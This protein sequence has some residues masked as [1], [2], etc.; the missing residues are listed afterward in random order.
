MTRRLDHS[1]ISLPSATLRR[2]GWR[3]LARHRWQTVLMIVGI[4][5]GVAVAVA[6]DLANAGASRAFD[7]STEAVT[8]KA[9]HEITG[10]SAG[11]SDNTYGELRRAGVSPAA[12]VVSEYAVSPQMGNLPMQLLGIDPFAEQPFRNYL[13]A[14]GSLQLSNLVDFFTLPGSVIISTETARRYGL[15]AGSPL[16]LTILGKEQSA[17]IVGLLQPASDLSRRMLDD[18][19]ICDVATAQELTGR[20]G[21]L[22]RI[23]LIVPPGESG[24]LQ[25]I[26]ALLPPT[27]H[28]SSVRAR[29]GAIEQ[30]TAAF[31]LDL[32]AM[33][34][35]ALLV[36]MFLIYNTIT[37]SV[38]QRRP[39]F[40]TL[41]CLGV[42]R[43]EVFL[44]V[45]GEALLVGITGSA[46]GIA[47][48][49][50]LGQGALRLVTQ[51]I[52]DL[53]F[54]VNVRDA[55]IA[56][57]SLVK[58]AVLGIA[59]TVVS[60][61]P[62]AWEAASAP[63]RQVLA[64]SSLEEKAQ[65]LVRWAA[66]AGL[67][68]ALAGAIL[69]VAPSNS[70][71]VAFAGTFA[72]VIGFAMLTPLAMSKL[73]R[74]AAHL[75]GRLWGSLG[76]MAPRNVVGSLSRTA[77]AMA[78]L[79]VAVSVAI[80]VSVMIS[81]FRFS[82]AGWLEQALQ[83]DIYISAPGLTVSRGDTPLDPRIAPL[84]ESNPDVARLDV[85]RATVVD[86]AWGPVNV[87]A[88]QNPDI[89]RVRT[90]I[91]S[92][93]APAAVWDAL[94]KGAVIVSEPFARRIGLPT[95]GGQVVLI[96]AGGARAF[97]VAGIYQD[98]STSEGIVTM[99]LAEYRRLWDDPSLSSLS[100][101]LRPDADAEATLRGLQQALA[102]L[103][104]LAIRPS[105]ELR[106]DVL[107][108][109]DRTFTITGALQ[110]LTTLV[111]FVGV[112]S[113]LLS[114]QLDRQRDFGILRAIGL[115]SGQMWGLVLLETGLMGA[116]AGLLALPTGCVV[117]WILVRVINLR[118]FGWTLQLRLEPA[119]FLAAVAVAV[120]ASIL[121]GVYPAQRM[122]R[123][124]TA[125]AIRYE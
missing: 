121:A 32:T 51:T 16:T 33:S 48:G 114:L 36:G 60:A 75:S 73:M 8:G 90:F 72:V 112:L 14:Q 40:G 108:I 101:R 113:A 56:G 77:V 78:A 42:T 122:A 4:T 89:G 107:V 58:G 38:V 119:P 7:L 85:M 46:L 97:P 15:S 2:I 117:S 86:S 49:V 31:R 45:T 87:A 13:Y 109:F 54:V 76:R 92:S 3:Y 66:L 19:I 125:D 70:L 35:L 79:M 116:V 41:R 98:Y 34:L 102:P 124:I 44:L 74:L 67:A 118:S 82:V 104:A 53:Y 95:Q 30:M 39:L 37:F 105:G 25:R 24:A 6:V 57:S 43:S 47:L 81:S 28:V 65:R 17:T 110:L 29:S 88:I 120:I 68:L 91:S 84:V 71:V 5:L 55:V 111:A 59:A 27:L 123:M 21:L 50:I 64:R 94:Q 61:V 62:P 63:A 12:P 20:S 26:A 23:D 93:L 99:S 52:N 106:R 103:Q 22:D 11:F 83:G 115:G 18:L 80:G 9:T 1:N 96:T 10:S 100:L 69:L